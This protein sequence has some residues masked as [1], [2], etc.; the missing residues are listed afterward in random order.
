MNTL[1]HILLLFVLLLQTSIQSQ[2][3]IFPILRCHGIPLLPSAF[4]M[5]HDVK[6]LLFKRVCVGQHQD[7]RNP[8]QAASSHTRNGD[9][10][11]K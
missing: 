2:D 6:A 7:E 9:T 5:P 10:P 8:R 4:S 1:E 3:K 11:H